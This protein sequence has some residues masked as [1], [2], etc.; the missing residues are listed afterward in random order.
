MYKRQN[1]ARVFKTFASLVNPIPDLDQRVA[2]GEPT[3]A[4]ECPDC[5]ALCQEIIKRPHQVEAQV[6]MSGRYAASIEAKSHKDAIKTLNQRLLKM[7]P[8]QILAVLLSL[9]MEITAEEEK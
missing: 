9:Q 5:G 8:A 3:P 6:R 2:S 4:G 7:T 1:C